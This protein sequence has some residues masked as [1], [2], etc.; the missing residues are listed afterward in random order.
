MNIYVKSIY[1]WILLFANLL[2]KSN[3]P[4]EIRYLSGL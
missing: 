3:I 2:R 4:I 1:K